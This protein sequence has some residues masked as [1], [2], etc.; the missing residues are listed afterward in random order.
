MSRS[1]RSRTS[2]TSNRKRR[3]SKDEL[4]ECIAKVLP[5]TNVPEIVAGYLRPLTALDV[6]DDCI[7]FLDQAL[8]RAP[9]K[10][11][12]PKRDAPALHSRPLRCTGVSVRDG[13]LVILFSGSSGKPVDYNDLVCWHCDSLPRWPSPPVD[14]VWSYRFALSQIVHDTSRAWVRNV[15]RLRSGS[16][17]PDDLRRDYLDRGLVELQRWQASLHR[18]LKIE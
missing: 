16:P 11:V 12:C 9:F 17:L 4:V 6:L 8:R 3:R 18:L 5:Q 7:L 15:D 13:R 14:H 10:H 1:K 2:A